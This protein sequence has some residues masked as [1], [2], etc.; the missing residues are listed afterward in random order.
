MQSLKGFGEEQKNTGFGNLKLPS[1]QCFAS[2]EATL[3][4][5]V[6]AFCA[7]GTHADRISHAPDKLV[8]V[9]TNQSQGLLAFSTKLIVIKTRDCALAIRWALSSDGGL[10]TRRRRANSHASAGWQ[11]NPRRGSA[12]EAALLAP[13]KEANCF[14]TFG[15]ILSRGEVALCTPRTHA[16]Q[17]PRARDKLV[18]VD[19]NQSQGRLAAPKSS[20]SRPGGCAFFIR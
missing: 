11:I 9:D 8:I 18:M 1:T 7:R 15:A 20:S 10:K 16:D 17:I 6:V 12:I 13:T 2:F 4:H 14:A 3:S 5:R 19:T